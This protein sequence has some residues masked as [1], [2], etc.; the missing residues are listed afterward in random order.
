MVFFFLPKSHSFTS[1]C[2]VALKLGACVDAMMDIRTR[3]VLL[4]EKLDDFL[5]LHYFELGSLNIFFGI[6]SDGIIM[7]GPC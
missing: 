3:N 4:L 5:D 7:W 2:H 1:I 6:S